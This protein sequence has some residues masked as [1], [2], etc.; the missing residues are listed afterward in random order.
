MTNFDWLFLGLRA[1]LSG[2]FI[3]YGLSKIQDTRAFALTIREYKVIPTVFNPFFAKIIPLAEIFLGILLLFGIVPVL[4]TL[5]LVLLLIAFSGVLLKTLLTTT[6]AIKD[7]GCGSSLATSPQKALVRNGV[8]LIFA[9]V[10][11]VISANT[12][13]LHFDWFLVGIEAIVLALVLIRVLHLVWFTRL[14][15][16][17]QFA[18]RHGTFGDSVTVQRE[19]LVK[20]FTTR[21]AFIRGVSA[22]SLGVLT[23]TMFGTPNITLADSPFC[24]CNYSSPCDTLRNINCSCCNSCSSSCTGSY[25]EWYIFCCADGSGRHCDVT[26]RGTFQLLCICS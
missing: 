16:F 25:Q 8:L 19:P 5:A 13:E 4:I 15:S 9:C 11:V 24:T 23:V 12:G 20:S 2:V 21:R 17:L 18:K 22:F 6:S 14:V 1:V 3:S 7:C 10:T 26:F